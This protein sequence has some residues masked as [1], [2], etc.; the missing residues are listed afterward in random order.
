MALAAREHSARPVVCVSSY[1]GE[2]VRCR[3]A[4][5]D[6]ESYGDEIETVKA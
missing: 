3:T 6:S 1:V 4:A 5:N 2:G